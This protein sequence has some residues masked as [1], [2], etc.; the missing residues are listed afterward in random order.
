[1]YQQTERSKKSTSKSSKS[2]NRSHGNTF[3]FVD[4]RN[5]A[6]QLKEIQELANQSKQPIQRVTNNSSQPI[7]LN[8]DGDTSGGTPKTTIPTYS[9]VSSP[10]DMI[11][12]RMSQA[13]TFS[14]SMYW[15]AM[16]R[17]T[18]PETQMPYS[19]MEYLGKRAQESPYG[20]VVM[21][22]VMP[23]LQTA[24]D[25][26]LKYGGMGG[27]YLSGQADKGM[28]YLGDRLLNVSRDNFKLNYYPEDGYIWK[29]QKFGFNRS[30]DAAAMLASPLLHASTGFAKGVGGK[31]WDSTKDRLDPTHLW[32]LMNHPGYIGHYFSQRKDQL[33]MPYRMYQDPR[34][35]GREMYD[36]IGNSLSIWKS[37]YD[38]LDSGFMGSV[39]HGGRALVD[40]AQDTI[41]PTLGV[42]GLSMMLY[43]SGMRKQRTTATM[44]HF[45]PKSTYYGQFAR[46][47][48]TK[49]MLT[50]PF[51]RVVGNPMFS[52]MMISYL[53]ATKLG[54][55]YEEMEAMREHDPRNY[56]RLVDNNSESFGASFHSGVRDSINRTSK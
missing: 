48:P 22:W 3:Q 32:T 36:H 49:M 18:N 7:Q 30:V 38:E 39:T 13:S 25:T 20:Q 23:H 56:Q 45:F 14:Q 55:N 46:F 47:L 2:N 5:S 34:G 15:D 11:K 52:A 16:H 40:Y 27:D 19:P 10:L 6:L 53:L 51:S 37:H 12:E 17:V 28:H 29:A 21:P 43:N 54:K 8:G 31:M 35:T 1:M 50:K 33:M 24:R 26:A 42:T 44:D 4:N 41:A 9:T